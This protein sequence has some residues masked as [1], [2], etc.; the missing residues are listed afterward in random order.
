MVILISLHQPLLANDVLVFE[1]RRVEKDFIEDYEMKLVPAN[2]TSKAKIYLDG[3]DLDR[4]DSNGMQVVKSIRI[5]PPTIAILID[6][7]FE[8][9]LLSGI[10]YPAGTVTTSLTLNQS[11]GKLKK[12]ETIEGGILGGNLGNGTRTSEETCLPAKTN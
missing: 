6:A 9:E 5:T 2:K 10:S 1:C 8:P 11:T 7:R 3:R 12:V 4:S